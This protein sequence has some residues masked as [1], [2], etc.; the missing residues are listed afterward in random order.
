MLRWE[1]FRVCSLFSEAAAQER[2]ALV[3][4]GLIRDLKGQIIRRRVVFN[5]NFGHL[6]RSVGFPG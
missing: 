6:R 4:E 5:G 1:S 3:C 2:C